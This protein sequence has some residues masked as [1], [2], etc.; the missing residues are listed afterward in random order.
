[1]SSGQTASVFDLHRRLQACFFFS[2]IKWTNTDDT[3]IISDDDDDVMT[4]NSLSFSVAIQLCS[5]RAK[6]WSHGRPH[7]AIRI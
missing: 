4:E 1:M 7:C 3:A 5:P 6:I 2:H